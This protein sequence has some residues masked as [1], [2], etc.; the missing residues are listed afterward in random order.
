MTQGA[1][2]RSAPESSPSD[3]REPTADKLL[4]HEPCSGGRDGE[5]RFWPGERPA[6]GAAAALE[7]Y[8]DRLCDD[9][10]S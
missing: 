8:P 2:V 10:K 9:K 7:P 3:N 4:S 6:V 5:P 1:V